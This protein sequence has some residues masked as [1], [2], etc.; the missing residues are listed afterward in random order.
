MDPVALFQDSHPDILDSVFGWFSW[1]E[2]ESLRLVAK[3]WRHYLDQ[4]FLSRDVVKNSLKVRSHAHLWRDPKRQPKLF[5]LRQCKYLV[6]S[7]STV[8]IVA[9]SFKAVSLYFSPH[10]FR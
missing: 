9:M 1:P 2:L 5:Q 4:G 8:T 10:L 6:D 7:P 3:H